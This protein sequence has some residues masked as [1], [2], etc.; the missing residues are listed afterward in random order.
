MKRG[1]GKTHTLKIAKR[2]IEKKGYTNTHIIEVA[3]EA[4]I[5]VGTL[6]YHF[7]RGKIDL[8][9]AIFKDITANYMKEAE[10]LGYTINKKFSS[11]E[12]ALR[13]H[14][15]IIVKLHKKYHI[16]IT[17]W[18]KEILPNL[19]NI[20]KLREEKDLAGVLKSEMDLFF[21][22]I[23]H[24]RKEFPKENLSLE[25]KGEQLYFI[26]QGI[27]NKYSQNDSVF[28]SEEDFINLLSKIIL[29]MLKD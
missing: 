10:K 23:N 29:V 26:L 12:E 14:L 6:Y 2:I 25:G 16:T 28:S 13:F 27:I 11:L 7:P 5:S 22:Q 20:V 21:E 19:E 8:L 1:R 15:G 9:I 24:I 17:A 4:K 18:E 3:R